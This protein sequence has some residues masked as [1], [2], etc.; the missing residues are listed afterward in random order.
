MESF[1]RSGGM[2]ERLLLRPRE[3]KGDGGLKR[4]REQLN[5]GTDAVRTESQADTVDVVEQAGMALVEL[6][7]NAKQAF[8]IHHEDYLDK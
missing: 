5:A 6:G 1:P 4:A 3:I 2:E 8:G 7:L